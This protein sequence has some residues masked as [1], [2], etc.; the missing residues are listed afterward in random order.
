[1]ATNIG[2]KLPPPP[3]TTLNPAPAKRESEKENRF[4]LVQKS[5]IAP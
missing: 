5:P 1:V 3:L 4:G 2:R